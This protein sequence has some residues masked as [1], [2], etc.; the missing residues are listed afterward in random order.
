MAFYSGLEYSRR[1]GGIIGLS[2]F[3]S[4]HTNTSLSNKNLP[5]YYSHGTEDTIIP[6]KVGKQNC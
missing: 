3:L 2:G 1:I 6:A 4:P 5:I